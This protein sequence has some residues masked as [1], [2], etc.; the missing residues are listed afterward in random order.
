MPK[1]AVVLGV[2][3]LL[4][5]GCSTTAPMPAAW[6]VPGQSR[7][8]ANVEPD[9]TVCS[10]VY[11]EAFERAKGDVPADPAPGPSG[12]AMAMQ[13]AATV[14]VWRS[15]ATDAFNSCMRSNRGQRPGG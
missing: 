15:I 7:V 2:S 13:A 8:N 4:L 10:A 14:T 12:S 5:E 3:A 11:S 1:W 6:D 9:V